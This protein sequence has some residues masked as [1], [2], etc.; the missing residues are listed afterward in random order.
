MRGQVAVEYLA[1]FAAFLVVLGAVVWPQA[2]TPSQTTV[3]E[4]S[5]LSRAR[6][7]ADGL[8]R[9]INSVY[10]GGPGACQT[11]LFN[12]E[13]S[14]RI[15]LESWTSENGTLGVVRVESGS[16]NLRV[17]VKYLSENLEGASQHLPP[18]TFAAKVFWEKL[19]ENLWYENGTL[20]IRINPG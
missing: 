3:T 11:F 15:F 6:M 1:I 17:P 20:F 9:A 14:C 16:E 19:E 10:L 7:L 18:G 8:A 13:R 12:L 5:S 2:I 4:V